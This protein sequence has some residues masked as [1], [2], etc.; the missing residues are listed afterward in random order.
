MSSISYSLSATF[1][2]FYLRLLFCSFLR[3][4][5]LVNFAYLY[6]LQLLTAK[7]IYSSFDF[8]PTT[9]KTCLCPH[10]SPFLIAF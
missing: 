7:K 9:N 8:K 4:R 1:G 2:L 10:L 5:E 6:N 3:M